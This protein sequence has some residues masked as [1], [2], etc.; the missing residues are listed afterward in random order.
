MK[1]AYLLFGLAAASSM[2]T[3]GNDIFIRNGIDGLPAAQRQTEEMEAA[4]AQAHAHEKDSRRVQ[5]QARKHGAKPRTS[6]KYSHGRRGRQYTGL[7]QPKP[8]F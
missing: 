5:K 4:A 6:N 3:A 1:K 7:K 8:G 2:C